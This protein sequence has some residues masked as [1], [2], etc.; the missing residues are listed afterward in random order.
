MSTSKTHLNLILSLALAVAGF[1]GCTTVPSTQLTNMTKT[2]DLLY[3]ITREGVIKSFKVKGDSYSVVDRMEFPGMSYDIGK[4]TPTIRNIIT[5][6][7]DFIIDAYQ[8]NS[9]PS[10]TNIYHVKGNTIEKLCNLPNSTYLLAADARFIY[11]IESKRVVANNNNTTQNNPV[12]YEKDLKI[13]TPSHFENKQFIVIDSWEDNKF[14]WYACTADADNIY[15]EYLA[16]KVASIKRLI[17][18]RVDKQNQEYREFT[19]DEELPLCRISDEG[20]SIWF[21]GTG[22]HTKIVKFDKDSNSYSTHI[23]PFRFMPIPHNTFSKPSDFIWAFSFTMDERTIYRIDKNDLNVRPISL[24]R[25]V[26]IEFFSPVYSDDDNL[27]IGATEHRDFPPGMN[28]VPYLINVRKSDLNV[29][30]VLVKP[31]WGESIGSTIQSFINWLTFPF[32]LLLGG[33]T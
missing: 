19:I 30:L 33:K 2:G 21:F 29:Q 10:E 20:D 9:F 27:W 22:S 12:R 1:L 16:A 15:G 32:A 11:G 26:M 17:L 13:K 5:V 7:Q 14:Y 4:T 25:G 23:I 3:I 8:A 31:T 18:A 6:K 28:N 24:P